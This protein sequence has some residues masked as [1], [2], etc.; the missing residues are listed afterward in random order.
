MY[1]QVYCTNIALLWFQF[2]DIE[3]FVE[4]EMTTPI[5]AELLYAMLVLGIYV[6]E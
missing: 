4:W 6:G 1:I 5:L 2:F 3:I